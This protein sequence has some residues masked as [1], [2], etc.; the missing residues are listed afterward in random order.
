MTAF[1]V[2]DRVKIVGGHGHCPYQGCVGTVNSLWP[3]SVMPIGVT[4]DYPKAG[5]LPHPPKICYRTTELEHIDPE[6]KQEQP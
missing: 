4:V 3:G 2:G 6:P 1:K 5:D